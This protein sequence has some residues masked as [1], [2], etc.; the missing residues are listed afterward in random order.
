[1]KTPRRTGPLA[2]LRDR[3]EALGIR[4]RK[5]HGQNFLLDRNQV[6][7]VCRDAR[8]RPGDLVLEVGP[9][10]GLLSRE[11]ARS[12]AG[13]LAVEI[14]PKLAR[15]VREE[16][17]PFPQV[18]VLEADILL[19]KNRLR[20]E[21]LAR[22]SALIEERGGGALKCVSNL[23]YSIAAPFLANLVADERP[24]EVGVFMLQR[25]VAERL[26]A[27]PGSPAYG[28][29]SVGIQLATARREILRAVP[30]EVFWPRPRVESAVARMEFYPAAERAALPW[31]ALRR[32]IRSVFSARRK[33][34]RNAL[35]GLLPRQGKR[36]AES[37]LDR[38]GYDPRSRGENLAPH[39][40]LRV[41]RALSETSN[42]S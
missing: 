28:A 30:P 4:P 25:E 31:D 39:D 20:P 12:G 41:A 13:L 18:L 9:G 19:R 26:T 17:A 24:W 40:F 33:T 3:L 15:L 32:V 22:L 42:R 14:D 36:A 7:A 21:V 38:F 29:L 8:L 35:A 11:I 16:T 5:R 2:L 1:M 37:L 23:P 6:L 34:L 10:S 27:T